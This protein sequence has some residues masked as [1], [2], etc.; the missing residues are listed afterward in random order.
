M[1]NSLSAFAR[2]VERGYEY[3]ET[4]V[5]ATADGV[6][7]VH[8]DERLERTTDDRGAISR[9]PWSAVRLARV[10]GREPVPQLSDALEAFPR[11]RF[12]I[13]VKDDAAVGPVLRVLAR[14]RA[15]HRVCLASFE[16]RRVR[17]LRRAGGPELLTSLGRASSTSLWLA[18]RSALGAVLP[19][20]GGG[21]AQLPASRHG[22]RVL[23]RRLVRRA[24]HWGLEVHAWTID[25]PVRMHQ[26]LDV[27]VDGL[28]TDR[29]DL[30][31]EVLAE[32]G[33]VGGAPLRHRPGA[34]RGAQPPT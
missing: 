12:N 34:E 9:L 26:L 23:D 28:I 8:H 19:R 16:E 22:V 1:E 25:D 21:A 4:D 7:V 32:R 10:G 13:D 6:V 2:A 11:A 18:S 5:R 14:Q 15:W 20:P 27:G 3:L 17:V 31:T 30:L 29:P 33:R 24:H